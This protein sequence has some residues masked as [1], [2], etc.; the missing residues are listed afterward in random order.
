MALRLPMIR[1]SL[2]VS[3]PGCLFCLLATS[4]FN[5]GLGSLNLFQWNPHWQCFSKDSYFCASNAS[6]FLSAVLQDHDVDFA[7]VVEFE[8][9]TYKA[10]EPWK[11]IHQKCGMD[12][13]L[14]IY[15]SNRWRASGSKAHGCM[16]TPDDRSFI[17]QQFKET[18]GTHRK[19][20]AVGAHYPHHGDHDR[21]ALK[22][23]LSSV[24]KA[25]GVEQIVLMADTNE[26][27]SMSNEDIMQDIGVKNTMTGTELKPTCCYDIGYIRPFDRIITNFGQK[28]STM[29]LLTPWF[30]DWAREGQL[31]RPVV[32]KMNWTARSSKK[33]LLTD[34]KFDVGG[35]MAAPQR[36]FGPSPGAFVGVGIAAL[37]LLAV[38]LWPRLRKFS[39][40]QRIGNVHGVMEDSSGSD[41]V[42]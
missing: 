25:T 42:E 28:M 5:M 16:N 35:F 27:A 40:A 9:A 8:D 23:G 11:M 31:H 10:P 21:A 2:W 22:S 6:S 4:L 37:L 32:G 20:I 38:V 18:G 1:P 39:I 14:L 13:V 12:M 7:N 29:V 34:E 3:A 19:L 33:A 36:R 26:E 15:H 24:R 41:S 17:V 30:P